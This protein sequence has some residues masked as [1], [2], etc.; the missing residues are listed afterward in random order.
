MHTAR[1]SLNLRIS[2]LVLCTQSLLVKNSAFGFFPLKPNHFF[3]HSGEFFYENIE[4]NN[5]KQ[6]KQPR[7]VVLSFLRVK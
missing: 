3:S 5:N 1:S 7:V 4:E 6:I 2:N